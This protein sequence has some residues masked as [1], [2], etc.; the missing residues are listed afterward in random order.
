M[1]TAPSEFLDYWLLNG[2]YGWYGNY[3]GVGNPP[4][5]IIKPANCKDLIERSLRQLM[6]CSF[7]CTN[8]YDSNTINNKS[9]VSYILGIHVFTRYLGTNWL[10]GLLGRYSGW[11]MKSMCGNPVPK[12]APSIE[13]IKMIK[14]RINIPIL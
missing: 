7:Q 9:D 12:Y 5:I 4:D 6:K 11:T 14:M 10:A 13:Y 3:F 8:A 1:L 2:P